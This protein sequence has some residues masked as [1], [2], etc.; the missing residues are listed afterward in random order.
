[1]MTLMVTLL[2]MMAMDIMVV[3]MIMQMM[4]GE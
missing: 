3:T 1:M 2:V 4:D